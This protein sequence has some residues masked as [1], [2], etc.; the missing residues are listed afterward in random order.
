MKTLQI[1]GNFK[2]FFGQIYAADKAA[3]LLNPLMNYAGKKV[4]SIPG[5]IH[6]NEQALADYHCGFSRKFK[7]YTADLPI[8]DNYRL[9][10]APS[11]SL[12]D[13]GQP[14]FGVGIVNQRKGKPSLDAV[15]SIEG[16]SPQDK[17]LRRL[18]KTGQ[19]SISLNDMY[20][21]LCLSEPQ[22]AHLGNKPGLQ[23]YFQ[24]HITL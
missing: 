15:V 18:E 10:W 22:L 3:E 7:N 9:S 19:D 13:F 11:G 5:Y 23:K 8:R 16:V 12:M 17:T 14:T 6:L 4:C 20:Q 2:Q 21:D 1:K 24:E